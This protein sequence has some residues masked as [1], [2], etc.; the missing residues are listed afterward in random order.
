MRSKGLLALLTILLV[1]SLVPVGCA[2]QPQTAK[3]TERPTATEAA[4]VE[5]PAETE[6]AKGAAT[7]E[8]PAGELFL[9]V[10]EHPPITLTVNESPWYPA[11]EKVVELYEQQTGN[12]VNLDATPFSGLLEKARNAVRDVESPYD[13]VTIDWGWA[14]E[15]YAGGFLTP[16]REIDPDFEWDS[17]LF[18]YADSIYWDDKTQWRDPDGEITTFSPQGNT[19]L[20]YYRADLYEEAGL[21]PPETWDDVI[22]ACEMFH[23]PPDMY[24]FVT[25]GERGNA[26]NFDFQP[27]LV[28]FGGDIIKDGQSGDFTVIINSPE[29]KRALDLFVEM[30]TKWGPPD[31]GAIGQSD[32]IQYM[33]T[34]KAVH[35]LIVTA[36]WANMDNPE[37]SAVVGKVDVTVPPKSADGVHASGI[38]NLLMG[39]PQNLPDERKQAALAFAKW[40]L[41]YQA[42]YEFGKSGAGPVRRDVYQS[43]LAEKPEFRWM[44]AHLDN[45]D[46]YSVQGLG[47][48]EGAQVEQIMGLRLNQALIGELSIAEALNCAAED[49]YKVFKENGRNTGMLEPLPE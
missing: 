27:F 19:Q 24:C 46:K 33:V 15:F 23:N 6:M 8:A 12:Q 5:E 31:A 42:Q 11:F 3:P 32:V 35:A 44:K 29:A 49:I 43:D 10:G 47:Y 39:I 4:E 37:K 16:L 26:I 25:R 22:K 30:L 14:V 45:L 7:E 38:G 1:V 36:A 20:L 18:T 48:K 13:I 21:D 40:F 17:A 34:G 2:P 28:G 41:T 9:D